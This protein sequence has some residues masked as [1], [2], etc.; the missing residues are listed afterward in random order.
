MS[1]KFDQIQAWNA[2]LA[3]LQT[4]LKNLSLENY[5]KYFD[6]LL[7]LCP[8]GYLLLYLT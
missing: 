3:A 4:N 7:A 6:D 1:S 5:L 8:L 2:E